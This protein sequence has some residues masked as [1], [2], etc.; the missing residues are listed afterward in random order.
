MDKTSLIFLL[1]KRH[2]PTQKETEF[3]SNN[4]N[5]RN[6]M[7]SFVNNGYSG[8]TFSAINRCQLFL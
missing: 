5:D 2:H 1:Q 3:P 8:T 4:M 6:L 7:E